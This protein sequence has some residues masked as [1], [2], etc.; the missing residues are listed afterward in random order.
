MEPRDSRRVDFPRENSR[1]GDE[2][3]DDVAQRE[4]RRMLPRVDER[5]V[6][7]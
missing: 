3:W 2:L 6:C 5:D 1:F 4:Q 7:A